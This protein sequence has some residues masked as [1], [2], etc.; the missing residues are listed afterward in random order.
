MHVS[1]SAEEQPDSELIRLYKE[2]ASLEVLGTLYARYMSLVYGVCLKYIKD[3]DESKDMVMQIF[4]K[5]VTTLVDHEVTHFRSW[6]YTTARNQC[7]MHLRSTKGRKFE[8]I[9]PFHME[10]EITA[11]SRS[12]GITAASSRFRAETSAAWRST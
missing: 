7:L 2:S 11:R 12:A 9:S 5:L 6:L 8:E 1:K 3:R 10:S 4:E